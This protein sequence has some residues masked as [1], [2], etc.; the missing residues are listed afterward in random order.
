M[1]QRCH[2]KSGRP[3][4]SVRA[5]STWRMWCGANLLRTRLLPPG[6]YID[7][8]CVCVCVCVYAYVYLCVW[9]ISS[10]LS[11]HKHTHTHSNRATTCRARTGFP[12]YGNTGPK[13]LYAR[14]TP[15]SP[16]TSMRK[17]HFL[18]TI[19]PPSLFL[20]PVHLSRGCLGG[21]V[22]CYCGNIWCVTLCVYMCFV[23]TVRKCVCVC[24]CGRIH[25]K[26]AY[27]GLI[28]S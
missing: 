15:G 22:G 2:C 7:T 13:L 26:A 28:K 12:S 6:G 21:G 23:Y 4:A 20:S 11:T 18:I 10:E 8:V 27:T 5:A 3:A 16:A 9:K 25:W 19:T 14:A 17:A 24:V 1:L